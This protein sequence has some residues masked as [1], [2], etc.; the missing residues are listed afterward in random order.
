MGKER[1]CSRYGAVLVASGDTGN[2]VYRTRCKM[3]A[4][5]YCAEVNRRN[6]QARII[7]HIKAVG[8]AWYFVTFTL[9]SKD[10]QGL[11]YSLMMW[12]NVWN[13]FMQAIRRM[14]K[15]KLHYIRVFEQHK[16]GTLHVH[17]LINFAP[18]DLEKRKFWNKRKKKYDVVWQSQAIDDVLARFG[19]GRVYT[20]LYVTPSDAKTL[21]E[22]AVRVS[23][24]VTKYLTKQNVEIIE[25]VSKHEGLRIRSIQTSQG[26]WNFEKDFS[27]LE[28]Q[29]RLLHIYEFE[30]SEEAGLYSYDINKDEQIEIEDF[31]EESYYPNKWS[32]IADRANDEQL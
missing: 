7:N 26:W 24:Y 20:W 4:C 17:M 2:F 19:L 9:E 5:P 8:G 25:Q 1:Y 29:V 15:D 11:V 31:H 23:G 10:H 22:A 27:E 3:W 28:W 14:T 32:D 13:A 12:R 18:S 6:W 30:Q 21:E 16:D